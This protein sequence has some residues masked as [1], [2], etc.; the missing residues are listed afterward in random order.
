MKKA[1]IINKF[2]ATASNELS[3]DYNGYNYLVIY[4]THVNGGW[5]A[6]INHGVSG[7]L[8]S[9]D[10]VYYNGD[11]IGMALNNYDTG[12]QIAIVIAS[13]EEFEQTEI[14]EQIKINDEKLKERYKM[15]E[16][17]EIRQN[18]GSYVNSICYSFDGYYAT[19][20]SYETIQFYNNNNERLGCVVTDDM[21]SCI[22]ELEHGADPIKDKWEDGTG[23]TL[24]LDGWE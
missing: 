18:L 12:E 13:V 10:D 16:I 11:Q 9:F 20:T 6:I 4:G 7:N 2:E 19:I 17:E 5:F 14:N 3:I 22:Y 21:A 8:A 23:Q 1:N 24:T 15:K